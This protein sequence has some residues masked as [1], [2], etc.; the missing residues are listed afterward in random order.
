M[1]PDDTSSELDE[2]KK[3]WKKK[4]WPENAI[5]E[6]IHPGNRIFVGTGCGE[7]QHSSEP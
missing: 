7:P 1:N 2:M 3:R 4:F 5:F 6:E